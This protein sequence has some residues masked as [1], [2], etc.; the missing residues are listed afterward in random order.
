MESVHGC[1]PSSFRKILGT[2]RSSKEAEKSLGG[3]RETKF[4]PFMHALSL[5][6][7]NLQL[8][9]ANL[10]DFPT[11]PASSLSIHFCFLLCFP[12]F[13]SIFPTQEMACWATYKQRR[14]EVIF[15]RTNLCQQAVP[16]FE[17][18]VDD[19]SYCNDHENIGASHA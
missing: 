6:K 11:T 4:A 17:T 2:F 19:T 15:S 1:S 14:D 7:T 16:N 10:Y 8:P 3:K 9:T 12:I 5:T 13:I 18:P